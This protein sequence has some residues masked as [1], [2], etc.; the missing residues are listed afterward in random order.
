MPK[1]KHPG[2]FTE[3]SVAAADVGDADW[4]ICSEGQAVN[5][6]GKSSTSENVTEF[7]T[8]GISLSASTKHK[9]HSVF[10][11]ADGGVILW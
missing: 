11:T 4:E 9:S 3:R 1:R 2:S 8:A 6:V 10:T 7:W 5:P